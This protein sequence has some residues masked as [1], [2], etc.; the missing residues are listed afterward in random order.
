MLFDRADSAPDSKS[1][2]L[3]MRCAEADGQLD[4]QRW[5][6]ADR[7][8]EIGCALDSGRRWCRIQGGSVY[9]GS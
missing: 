7:G 9:S 5:M 8:I 3:A 4:M 2:I 1:R 6:I